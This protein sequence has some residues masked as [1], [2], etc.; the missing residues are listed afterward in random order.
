MSSASHPLIESKEG[1]ILEER[2]AS[3]VLEEVLDQGEVVKVDDTSNNIPS[4]LGSTSGPN[5]TTTPL[6]PDQ[7]SQEGHQEQPQTQTQTQTPQQEDSM[8]ATPSQVSIHSEDPSSQEETVLPVKTMI[9]EEEVP[10]LE[11]E[12]SSALEETVKEGQMIKGSQQDS[13]QILSEEGDQETCPSINMPPD[14]PEEGTSRPINHPSSPPPLPDRPSAAR[15]QESASSASSP[16]RLMGPGLPPRPSQD[17]LLM[18]WEHDQLGDAEMGGT[19]CEV[20]NSD[21]D[22]LS[23]TQ[24]TRE[25]REDVPLATKDRD[26]GAPHPPKADTSAKKT[27]SMPPA[28]DPESTDIPQNS[29]LSSASDTFRWV[30]QRLS[31]PSAPITHTESKDNQEATPH[32][33]SRPEI[34][35]QQGP[36]LVPDKEG[37]LPIIHIKESQETTEGHGEE[38]EEEEEE[39]EAKQTGSGLGRRSSLSSRLSGAMKRFS[40]SLSRSKEESDALEGRAEEAGG[41]KHSSAS[42]ERASLLSGS[43]KSLSGHGEHRDPIKGPSPPGELTEAADRLQERGDLLQGIQNRTEA[44]EG[45]AAS[46]ADLAKEMAER[47]KNR[48]WWQL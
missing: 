27:K 9:P 34:E 40:N 11:M 5:P 6:T 44:L 16:Q 41:R 25:I 36:P 47:E 21:H 1:D 45:Q 43:G 3:K 14:L 29:F 10:H 31:H 30:T 32:P 17:T 7:E 8:I 37:P 48:K 33:S 24:G 46:F 22:L 20:G 19:A 12:M 18:Q 28:L 35:S 2:M 42:A 15:D 39:E 23:P 13:K 4:T 38:E 26:V